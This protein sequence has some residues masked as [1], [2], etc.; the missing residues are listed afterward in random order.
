[1]EFE[2]DL[3]EFTRTLRQ[4][5]D[6]NKRESSELI[7]K[8]AK[9]VAYFAS[10]EVKIASAADI[11]KLGRP[12]KPRKQ[13]SRAKPRSKTNTLFHVLATKGNKFGKAS[14]G[15]GNYDLALKTFN[16]RRKSTHYSKAL[17]TKLARQIAGKV[18]EFNKNPDARG[19]AS[20]DGTKATKASPKTLTATLEIPGLET[21]HYQ[22]VMKPALEK[23]LRMAIKDMQQ[24]LQRKLQEVAD[25]YSA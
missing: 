19:R 6:A 1:M 7:N 17:F 24:Y 13:G 4:Y 20:I 23:G 11:N 21:S 10:K 3:T 12:H 8:K 5:V 2:V 18:Y 9:D 22:D 16:S 15:E 25:K 14:R